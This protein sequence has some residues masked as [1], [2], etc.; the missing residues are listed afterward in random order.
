MEE[1]IIIKKLANVINAEEKCKNR[2]KLKLKPEFDTLL[3]STK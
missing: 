1:A 2:L 3:L